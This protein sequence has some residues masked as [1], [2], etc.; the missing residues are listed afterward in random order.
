MLFYTPTITMEIS[1][2]SLM[3]YGL[4]YLCSYQNTSMP[5]PKNSDTSSLHMKAKNNWLS[6]SS[7]VLWRSLWKWRRTGISFSNKSSRKFERILWTGWLTVWGVI[8]RRPP[9]SMSSFP[10][11]S[12]WHHSK[13][14]LSMNDAW[15][16]VESIMSIL[17]GQGRIG[18]KFSRNS[19]TFKSMMLMEY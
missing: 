2:L 5:M 9:K 7:Q 17:T 14:I 11:Q 3:I 4:W 19:T 18:S 15:L 13:N 10:L 6:L 8:L 12:S 16:F 1:C